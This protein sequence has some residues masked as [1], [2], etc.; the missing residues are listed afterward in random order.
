MKRALLL[1][2]MFAF[3]GTAYTASASIESKA[4]IY[5][6]N[7]T[8][9]H[10]CDEDCKKNCKKSASCKKGSKSSAKKKGCCSKGGSSAA[11]KSC[12]GK[13]S[14]KA[15]ASAGEKTKKEDKK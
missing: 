15:S 7:C 9:G 11:A 10:K 13:S 3:L 1:F 8:G 4:G 5:C 2:A 6:D 14:T 12:H